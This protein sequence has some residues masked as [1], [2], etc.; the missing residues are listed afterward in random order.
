MS[1]TDNKTVGFDLLRP[2]KF[3]VKRRPICGSRLP[4]EEAAKRKKVA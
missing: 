1:E 3:K 4:C 2:S